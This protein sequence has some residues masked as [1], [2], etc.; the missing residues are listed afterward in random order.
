MSLWHWTLLLTL[1]SLAVVQDLAH[2]R[3]PNRLLWPTALVALT[4]ALY[5]GGLR[6]GLVPALGAGVVVAAVF[7]PLYLLRQLGGGDLKLLATVG[8][9]VGMP[10]VAALCLSVAMAG[11]L[12]ALI[13][14][15]RG[16]ASA[17]TAPMPY[18]LAVALGT[19]AHGWLPLTPP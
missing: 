13:W 8:L 19:A 1:L 16:T 10:R 18:A 14:H 15:W 12:Q 3:I 17:T 4:L 6:A 5:T 9:L 11:G 2:R 7:S